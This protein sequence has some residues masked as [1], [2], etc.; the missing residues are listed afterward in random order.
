MTLGLR[1]RKQS[2]VT[3]SLVRVV[4][5]HLHGIHAARCNVDDSSTSR[6]NCRGSATKANK[7]KKQSSRHIS[8]F[9]TWKQ[10]F[11]EEERCERV[12]SKCGLQ[13]VFCFGSLFEKNSGIV[14]KNILSFRSAKSASYDVKDLQQALGHQSTSVQ[15]F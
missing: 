14:N 12:G 8:S 4:V 1:V 13:P 2:R 6:N 11:G 10:I 15:E 7:K 9:L 5:V 3:F